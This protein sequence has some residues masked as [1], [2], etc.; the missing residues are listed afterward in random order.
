MRRLFA[1]I[2]VFTMWFGFSL[3]T[4][5]AAL[6]DLSALTPCGSSDAFQQRLGAEVDGYSA[7]L[8]KFT[9]GSAP[10]KYLAGKIDATKARFAK[11]AN[12]SLLCGEDGLP[13]LITDGRWSHAGEF[14]IPSVMFLFI[15]GWIGWVGRDYLRAVSKSEDACN[16]E[17]VLDLPLAIKSMLTGFVWPLAALKEFASGELLAPEKE[18]TVSP[19]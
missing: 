5:P 19:R 4:A 1:L 11:Y 10:A 6:A 18:V 2:L 16:K 9:P 14:L 15:T 12:S 3:A 13:H 8:A 17:I 7:R